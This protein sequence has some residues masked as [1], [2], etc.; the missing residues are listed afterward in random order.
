M[1]MCVGDASADPCSSTGSSRALFVLTDWD[2][3]ALFT[4]V[5]R[6]N[7][8]DYYWKPANVKIV[9]FLLLLIYINIIKTNEKAPNIQ[10]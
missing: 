5:C 9:Y 2:K 8:M 7:D 3:P 1:Q 4:Y 10:S 6:K